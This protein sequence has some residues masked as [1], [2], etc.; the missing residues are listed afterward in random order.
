MTS[1]PPS[2]GRFAA[3]R[4]RLPSPL[5]VVWLTLVW[6]LLW[7]DVTLGNVVNGL[8][9]AYLV[10]IL[11][12]LPRV[13]DVA[14]FRP[15]AVAWLVLRFIADVTISGF[16]VA[17][18]ALRPGTPKS[19]VIRVQLRSHSDFFLA[20]TAALTT[21]IP[22]SVAINARRMDGIIYLHVFDVP[23]R[24]TKKYLNEFATTVMAQEERLLR[25][26]GSAAELV[27][28]GYVPGWRMGSGDLPEYTRGQK[29]AKARR[30]ERP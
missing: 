12:P 9:L 14:A 23:A 16:R 25:A 24:G 18:V 10:G 30:G 20:T 27:D 2:S 1:R 22:G 3:L 7:G 26:F 13:N 6:V 21:L 5:N 29:A 4:N 28:A 17:A 15:L 11:F 8:V 19:A